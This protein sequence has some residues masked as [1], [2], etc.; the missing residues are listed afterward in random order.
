M[1]V[2]AQAHTER[3]MDHQTSIKLA[4][5]L[6]SAQLYALDEPYSMPLEGFHQWAD[7]RRC[8]AA[9]RARSPQGA[10]LWILLIEWG[11]HRRQTG[12]FY[13]VLF[14][15]SRQGPICELHK[16]VMKD[17]EQS[18]QWTYS[19]RKQDGQNER[20]RNNFALLYGSETAKLNLPSS[21]K[22]A[23]SFVQGLFELADVRLTADLLET[24]SDL[25][26]QADLNAI[27]RRDLTPTTRAAMIQARLGQGDFRKQMLELWDGKCAVTGLA[28]LSVIIA[29]HAKPWAES[30]DE[31]RLNPNNG[32]PLTANLDKLFDRHLITFDPATGRM[33]ISSQIKEDERVILGIPASLRKR[34]SPDQARFLQHHLCE[35]SV[36]SNDR[37]GC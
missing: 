32:L 5:M 6:R 31:E 8:A 19:P 29:S 30:N 25:T 11:K 20:R 22:G 23:D 3:Q 24:N 26:I 13:V 12:N 28:V 4:T 17:G 18:L 21:P 37:E 36:R 1:P 2:F 14:P 10:T 34:P 27:A 35:F 33:L 9:F 7:G 15:E 16:I